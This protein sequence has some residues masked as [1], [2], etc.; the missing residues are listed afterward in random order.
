LSILSWAWRR[1]GIIRWPILWLVSPKYILG[2]NAII[3]NA[4]GYVWLQQHR[5]WPNQAWGLPGGIVKSNEA[6]EVA[7]RREVFE[8]TGLECQIDSI[9]ASELFFRRGLTLFYTARLQAGTLVLDTNE[10]LA[11]QYF[12]LAD[13]PKTLLPSHR[14]L[15]Q[16]L[17][18]LI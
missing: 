12:D 17:K 14:I 15:L 8:E 18:Y 5:F 2:A 1:M 6:P 7:L 9:V 10:I 16:K 13:L 11:A 3:I 4:Q